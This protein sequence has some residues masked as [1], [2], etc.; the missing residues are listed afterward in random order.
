MVLAMCPTRGLAETDTSIFSI[1][2]AIFRYWYRHRNNRNYWLIL[3][4]RRY[5]SIGIYALQNIKSV[6]YGR[7]KSLYY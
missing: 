2:G 5:I 1:I 7:K 6:S 4:S 3:A